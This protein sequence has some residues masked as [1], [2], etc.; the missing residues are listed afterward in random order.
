MFEDDYLKDRLDLE[1][2]L[3]ACFDDYEYDSE[4]YSDD[5]EYDDEL[6]DF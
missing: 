3:N 1:R 4:L 5:D 6:E 2:S